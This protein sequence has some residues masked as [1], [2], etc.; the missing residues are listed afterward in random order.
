MGSA[1]PSLDRPAVN[2]TAV[3]RPAVEQTDAEP[4]PTGSHPRLF[5]LV[6]LVLVLL[7]A[8]CSSTPGPGPS[9]SSS[10]SAPAAAKVTAVLNQFRDNYSKQIIEIQL[11]NTTG[12][13]LTVQAATVRSP[14]FGSGITWAAGDAGT[15]LPP[16]QAKSLPAALPAASCPGPSDAAGTGTVT[17][18]ASGT[19]GT[20]GTVGDAA[21]QVRDADGAVTQERVAVTDPFG[22]LVRNNVEMCVAQAAAAVA[23]FRFDPDVTVAAGSRAAVLDLVIT[24]RNTAGD[25][26]GAD[27]GLTI[28]SVGGTTLL[29]EDAGAPWPHGLAVSGRGAPQRLRLGIRPA[30]CDPH[31]VADDK[32]GTLIPLQI[33]VNG[34]DGVLKVDTGPLLRGRIYDFVTAACGRQ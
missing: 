15:D 9:T 23:D 3:D 4:R 14:L 29:E 26:G 13:T 11:T 25:A 10:G 19:P 24:P 20:P 33:T 5:P 7:S 22:V 8:A 16:G 32:V 17:G 6:P 2:R 1:F 31:A 21:V 12:S 34:R 30:R 27:P 18:T 28:D